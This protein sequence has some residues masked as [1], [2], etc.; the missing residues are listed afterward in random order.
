MGMIRKDKS[1]N[2]A[3][4]RSKKSEKRFFNLRIQR[5]NHFEE[6]H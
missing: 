3:G 4:A 6:A 2:E 1:R 5:L